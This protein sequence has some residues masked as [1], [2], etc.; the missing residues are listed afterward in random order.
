MHITDLL[1]P[2]SVALHRQVDSISAALALLVELMANS[3][4]LTD[5]AAFAKDVQAREALGGTCLGGG[6]AIPHAK[7]AAVRAPGLAALTLDPPLACTTPDGV[8]VRMMFLI[9]APEDAN[10]LHVQVLAELA[11]LMLDKELC[12]QLVQADTPDAFCG[13][14]AGQEKRQD[15]PPVTPPKPE[16]WRFVAVTACP[17]GLAHTYLAA[18]ALQK[19]AQERGVSLKVE[20]NGAAG[21]SDAP[22][23][24]LIRLSHCQTHLVSCRNK[25]LQC[26]NGK[27]RCSHKYNPH[28]IRNPPRQILHHLH[29]PL[30]HHHT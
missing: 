26:S 20:T 18:E 27:I 30:L 2:G 4:N 19:A 7:S 8:P 14:I 16:R 15:P 22:P 13:L 3:G 9:A 24:R 21:V 11:T 23:L 12:A 10:D 29:I 5:T 6:L 17:T 25:R 1:Q 28:L